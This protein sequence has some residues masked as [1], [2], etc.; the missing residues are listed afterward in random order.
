M[1]IMRGEAGGIIFRGDEDHTRFYLFR[2]DRHGNYNLYLFV[3]E[4]GAHAQTL[5][6]GSAPIFHSGL[7]KSNLIAVI[8][9]R[10]SLYLF[11]NK[12]FVISAKNSILTHGQIGVV[13]YAYEK[14]A[15]VVYSNAQVWN[16]L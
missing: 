3:D 10:S 4:Q 2:I 12:Q 9:Q 11:V 5:K 8:A 16:L 6:R 15:S 1:K 7:E 14:P 13:A